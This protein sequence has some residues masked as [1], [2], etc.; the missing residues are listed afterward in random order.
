MPR[1]GFGSSG[2]HVRHQIDP[3]DFG[4]NDGQ[5][6][7][8]NYDLA[9]IEYETALEL[10]KGAFDAESAKRLM[11]RLSDLTDAAAPI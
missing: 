5:T 10:A 3:V 4:G 6:P 7:K 9:R 11:E 2:R 1:A 8:G